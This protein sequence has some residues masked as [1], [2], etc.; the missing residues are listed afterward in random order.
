[1]KNKVKEVVDE[2]EKGW[3]ISICS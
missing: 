1:S 3:Y 2:G